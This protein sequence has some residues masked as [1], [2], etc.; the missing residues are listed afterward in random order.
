[1]AA[2][3]ATNR[4]QRLVLGFFVLVWIALAAILLVSPQIYDST[5]SLGPGDHPQASLTFLISISVLIAVLALG[6]VRRWRWT[7]W[8]IVA[9]FLFGI[10]RVLASVLQLIG[11]L[12]SVGPAWY[13][14]L[15]GAIGVIQFL[16]ALTMVAGY[17][18]A[19]PW[20]AF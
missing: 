12:P 5:L 14:A 4:T 20:G 9:A 2:L 7:F 8:L 6:V 19:G 15:Q 1:M 10:V 3:I 11:V 16:I 17:R 18:K 13:T